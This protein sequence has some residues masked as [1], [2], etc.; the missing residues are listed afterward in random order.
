MSTGHVEQYRILLP[1]SLLILPNHASKFKDPFDSTDYYYYTRNFHQILLAH[2]H[3]FVILNLKISI[4][5]Y[6]HIKQ[7]SS[8]RY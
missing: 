4:A 5:N 3:Y 7:N 1:R 6:V 2:F 8:I